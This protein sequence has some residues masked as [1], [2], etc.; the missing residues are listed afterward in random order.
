VK[1]DKAWCPNCKDV[2]RDVQTFHK[3]RGREP[4]LDQT[5]ASIGVPPFDI[6]VS[7][8][9]ERAVGFELS[10]DAKGVLGPLYRTAE[11]ELE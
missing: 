5:L 2:R 6:L 8:N 3:I 9:M 7:R 1:A 10:G 11:L 4:F